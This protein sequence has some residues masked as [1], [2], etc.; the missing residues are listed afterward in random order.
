M[1]ALIRQA[2]A[3]KFVPTP[4]AATTVLVILDIVLLTEATVPTSTNVLKA[5]TTA[6]L[7]QP[8]SIHL[9][10]II[11]PATLG[12]LEMA[13]FVKVNFIILTHS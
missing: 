5:L 10:N 1:N 6:A 9:G 13:H 7:W 8:A 11:V 4:L 12:I 3:I 2:N